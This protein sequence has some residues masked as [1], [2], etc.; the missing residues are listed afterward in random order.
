MS[1]KKPAGTVHILLAGRPLCDFHRDLPVAWPEG[2]AWVGMD[3]AERATCAQCKARADLAATPE[4][5]GHAERERFG[6]PYCRSFNVGRLTAMKRALDV[7]AELVTADNE[8]RSTATEIAT[9]PQLYA[10]K[11]REQ[12][13]RYDK[14]FERARWLL[15]QYGDKL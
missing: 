1:E 11:K 3:D 10:E 9:T 2:H 12:M 8:M 4:A 5:L 15:N 14:A 6:C 7:V 13:A